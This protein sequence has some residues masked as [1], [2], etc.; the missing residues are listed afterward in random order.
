M[1]ATRGTERT[2]K[3]CHHPHRLLIVHCQGESSRVV[4]GGGT[5]LRSGCRRIHC[6]ALLVGMSINLFNLKHIHF[7]F[8]T[9]RLVSCCCC[10]SSSSVALQKKK[11]TNCIFLPERRLF[12]HLQLLLLLSEAQMKI[13]LHLSAGEEVA[14][15]RRLFL[16]MARS[17]RGPEES[18]QIGR[19]FFPCTGKFAVSPSEMCGYNCSNCN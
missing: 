15:K 4:G 9:P 6:T 16:E 1:E 12:L 17:R 11:G 14:A 5:S 10:C 3:S 2:G 13:P 7:A 18:Q 8:A 19:P